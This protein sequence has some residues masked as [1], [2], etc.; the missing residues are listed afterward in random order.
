ME[1]FIFREGD[2]PPDFKYDYEI[3]LYNLRDHRLLQT[4]DGWVSY[5]VL[6]E[7]K[8]TIVA[9]IH[10][11]IS[12]L[13]ASSPFKSPF[14]SVESTSRLDP[15]V[16]FDFLRFIE[17][18]LRSRGIQRII[19]KNPPTIYQHEIQTL[20][21]VFLL[22]LNYQITNAEVGAV[23]LVD[24][25][26]E[27][28]S[29]GWEK[30]KLRQAHEKS[31]EIK[32]HPI[33]QLKKIYHFIF[34]CREQKGYRSSMTFDEI[35]KTAKVFPRRFLLTGIYN[36]GSM[37]AGSICVHSSRHVLYHFYSDHSRSNDL[38]KPT[39]FL[40]RG[41]YE[42][43]LKNKITLLDLGTSAITGQP[44][45]GLLSFKLRLGATPVS[46]LTFEKKL[47]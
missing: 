15:K 2:P 42:Y 3:S 29:Q 23:L 36:N 28:L 40:L 9:G 4:P 22:N 25:P 13:V 17:T 46:K 39:I 12:A 18:C 10:F 5:Y 34:A 7:K 47:N 8:R 16:L 26:F 21:Q 37:V 19:I 20:L 27:E 44:N 41:L 32:H 30:R 11:H 1:D 33:G 14:G 31:L 24:K 38:T 35:Q 6:Q 43:A 45:F